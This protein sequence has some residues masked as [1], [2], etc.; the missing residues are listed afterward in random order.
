MRR[1]EETPYDEAQRL[2]DD[3][4]SIEQVAGEVGI[5]AEDAALEIAM[6]N[7]SVDREARRQVAE[8]RGPIVDAG[9]A[10]ESGIPL[11]PGMAED[12]FAEA[13]ERDRRKAAAQRLIDEGKTKGRGGGMFAELDAD[14]DQREAVRRERGGF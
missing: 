11:P 6:A 2:L 4:G 7:Q 10:L 8:T 12:V 13:D 14:H 3:D 5:S 1:P 9:T